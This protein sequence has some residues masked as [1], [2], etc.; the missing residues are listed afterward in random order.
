[1]TLQPLT[2]WKKLHNP[3]YLGAYALQPGEEIVA[4]IRS[5]GTEDVYDPDS[6]Q[7]EPCVV[8]Q[9]VEKR[10][11]PMILNA[12]NSKTIAKMYGTPYIEEW[13]GRRVQIYVE[14]VK[15]FGDLVD[16]LRIRPKEPNAPGAKQPELH[17]GHE[18]WQSAVASVA[19]DNTDLEGVRKYFS[20]STANEALFMQAVERE[21]VE[22]A[23]G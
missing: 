23:Q 12:T 17:P 14:Q 19:A 4:T 8:M 7:K 20:L 10:L 2:H 21:A 11:K 6:R 9:F 16:A 13:E 15:A 22:H 1:M 3:D 5:V 18:K